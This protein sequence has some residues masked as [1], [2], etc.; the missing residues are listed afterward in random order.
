MLTI[1]W[2]AIHGPTQTDALNLLQA[3]DLACLMNIYTI[4]LDLL[5]LIIVDTAY[6][7]F[8]TMNC[9]TIINGEIE[10]DC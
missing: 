4:L 3:S 7:P 5:F 9:L 10:R 1:N 8:V 6:N 2:L